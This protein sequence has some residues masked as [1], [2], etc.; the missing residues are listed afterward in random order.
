MTDTFEDDLLEDRIKTNVW[1]ATLLRRMLRYTRPYVLRSLIGFALVMVIS[2]F[3]IIPPALIGSLVDIVFS[4]DS[5]WLARQVS[6]V[7]AVF[8][9]GMNEFSQTEKLW[10]FAGLFLFVRLAAFFIEWGNGY[11]LAGLGQRVIYDI[12]MQLFNH[13]HSLSLSYFHRQPVGRLVTRTMND[14]A[15]MEEMFANALVTILKDVS[16]LLG[17]VVF[18]L[19]INLELGL[20]AMSVI[21]FMIVA[22]LIFRKYA[23]EAYRRWRAA[24]SRINAFTAET[25]GGIRVVQ[26][27]HKERLNDA[28]YDEINQKYKNHF[29]EQRKAWAVFRPVN[30]TLSA[31][32]IAL[33]LWFGGAAVLGDLEVA[34][35]MGEQQAAANLFT[36]GLLFAFIGY[37][38][39]FFTPIRDLTEKFDIVQGAMTSAERI[40]TILDERRE[41]VDLPGASDFGRVQGRV[42]F[43]DVHFEYKAAEPVLR[44]VSF[45]I[46][47][48]QTVAIVGHTGAGKTTIINLVSRF[49]DIQS[50]SVNVD[51]RNVR[52]YTLAGLRRHVAVVHQDVFLFAGTVVDNVRLGDESI[53]RER[54]IEACKYVGAHGFIER[55]NGGYD[56]KVEEGGKTF[57]AGERQLLSFARALVF[58]PAILILDEATSSIDTHTEE[59]IQAALRKL[60][61]GRTSIVIAHRLSTIQRADKILV[62][63]KG[64]LA[65]Q[66]THQ[67][68]LAQRGIYFRLYQLQYSALE[69]TPKEPEFAQNGEPAQTAKLEPQAPARGMLSQDAPD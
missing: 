65:E 20:I 10:V 34:R 43:D 17:I 3:A 54:V 61:Q 13:I 32:G 36:V 56:A 66:G 21:P 33:V 44:G 25:L 22:T 38:E 39:L 16:M 18:L 47:P 14:V 7:L 68:L 59:L 8:I 26:L 27:F 46:A 30:T 69:D 40:F 52:E 37:A 2:V 9:P 4:Q 1:D 48:G 42:T 58:D 28:T 53:S 23:R 50:G 6:G 19:V 41:I 12:R 60:T 45:D 51:G 5:S 31:V 11:L 67:E 55:L 57:S 24:L 15:S 62:M 35:G 49:Y 63:H 29:L 64:K